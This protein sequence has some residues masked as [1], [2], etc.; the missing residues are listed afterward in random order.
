MTKHQKRTLIQSAQKELVNTLRKRFPRIEFIGVEERP[1]G[2]F[3]LHLYAP[4]RNIF[5]WLDTIGERL[6]ELADK[7]LFI[8]VLPHSRKSAKTSTRRAA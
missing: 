2:I 5:T 6:E 7:G 1:D 4:Y 8:L 3:A